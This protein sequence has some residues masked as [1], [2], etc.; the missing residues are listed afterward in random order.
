MLQK[1]IS[2][3]L[4]NKNMDTRERNATIKQEEDNGNCRRI[5]CEMTIFA[6]LYTLTQYSTDKDLMYMRK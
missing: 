1:P 4:K 5:L 2:K 3:R 6:Y